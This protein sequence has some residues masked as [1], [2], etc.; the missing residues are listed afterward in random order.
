MSS[1]LRKDVR[2]RGEAT[3]AEKGEDSVGKAPLREKSR[4]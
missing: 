1:S 2:Q 4:F 3:M